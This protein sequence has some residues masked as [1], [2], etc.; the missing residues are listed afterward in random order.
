[1]LIPRR[2]CRFLGFIFDTATKTISFFVSYRKPHNSV[3][4]QTL[5][6]WVKEILE[7]AGIN[8]S[9]F[10]AHSTRHA[11]TSYAA[12]KGINIDEICR[13][14][15]W[16]KTSQVFARFYNRPVIADPSFQAVILDTCVNYT[17]DTFWL[18]H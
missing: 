15:G 14:A 10:S 11:S 7:A 5:G 8:V 2:S 18:I 13:T 9:I 16:S 4:S 12:R 1:M 3:S 6:R 17:C